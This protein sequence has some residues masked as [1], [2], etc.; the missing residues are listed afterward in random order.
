MGR[1]GAGR[2]GSER[3]RADWGGE[4]GGTGWGGWPSQPAPGPPA[5]PG[6]RDSGGPPVQPA[7]AVHHAPSRAH[8][9]AEGTGERSAE[10]GRGVGVRWERRGWSLDAWEGVEDRH[11]L[12]G[13]V[14][15]VR[16]GLRRL[17]HGSLVDPR[18]MF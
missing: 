16:R 3:S 11:A 12:I 5:A 4:A 15:G 18:Y 6:V 7:A 2:H 14:Q 10:E 1:G 9:A 8:A 17:Y 13:E